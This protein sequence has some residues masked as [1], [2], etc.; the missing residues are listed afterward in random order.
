[1]NDINIDG[2]QQVR[3]SVS[4]AAMVK[5]GRFLIKMMRART[6]AGFDKFHRAFKPY[7]TNKFARPAAGVTKRARK[8][9]V[10]NGQIHYF[11]TKAGSLWMVVDGYL[12]LKKAI[13]QAT[14]WNGNVNL[15]LSGQMLRSMTVVESADNSVT[16]GFGRTEDA[17]KAFWN[18]EK[19][20]DFFG[21]TEDDLTSFAELQDIFRAGLKL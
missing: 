11:N 4:A 20:R 8:I 16:I 2:L 19:G 18:I 9:L 13:Y 7:S 12:A 14:D 21:F 17:L 5:A 15:A 3:T 10:D 6:L 1:M